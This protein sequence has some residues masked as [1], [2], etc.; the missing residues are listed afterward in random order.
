[1]YTIGDYAHQGTADVF[2]MRIGLSHY[3]RLHY[4]LFI[5]LQVGGAFTANTRTWP[6]VAS[7][8]AQRRRRW[9]NI[10][11]TLGQV[12]VFAGLRPQ[13]LPEEPQAAS[14][15]PQRRSGWSMECQ[16]RRNWSVLH[17]TRSKLGPRS[18][19]RP[20][21]VAKPLIK[22]SQTL[23]PVLKVWFICHPF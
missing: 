18:Y 1:M 8:L 14:N 23:H 15:K 12:F 7:I 5:S 10:K 22:D 2:L 4:S 21:Q 17:L 20:H 3:I 11:T 19:Y 9:L 16:T 13:G 6:N